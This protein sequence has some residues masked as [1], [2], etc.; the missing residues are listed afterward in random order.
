MLRGC[1]V[2]RAAKKGIEGCQVETD[3]ERSDK[4]RFQN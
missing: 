2:E 3:G 1:F 4:Q